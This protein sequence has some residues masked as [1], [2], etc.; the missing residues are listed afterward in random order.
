MFKILADD[1][2]LFLKV[3]DKHKSAKK[4]NDDLE[5]ISY[6]AY[7]WKLQFN[8]DVNKQA[9]EVVFS[10]KASL[11]SL[12]HLHI[13]FSYNGISK[14]PHQKYLGILLNSKLKFNVHVD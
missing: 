11:N 9:N 13:K 5:K 2:S 6:W 7:Q 1:T 3:S 12:S 14:C 10:R 8:P 4:L